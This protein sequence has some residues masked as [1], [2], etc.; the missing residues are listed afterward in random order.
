[1]TMFLMGVGLVSSLFAVLLTVVIIYLEHGPSVHR[2][3][4]RRKHLRYDRRA[5]QAFIAH[6]LRIQR[7]TR[8][9]EDEQRRA[10]GRAE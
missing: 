9:F 8:Q 10:A 4:Q 3:R 1:M 6:E 7:A 5:V 2:W